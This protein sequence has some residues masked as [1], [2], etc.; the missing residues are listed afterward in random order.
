MIKS[1]KCVIHYYMYG[2]Q[3]W[4]TT[5][6]NKN[7]ISNNYVHRTRTFNAFLSNVM[8][9]TFSNYVLILNRQVI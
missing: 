5:A 1:F 3:N 6:T 7:V 4:D 8:C 2:T 9:N